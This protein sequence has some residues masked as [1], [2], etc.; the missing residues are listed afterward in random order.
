[1]AQ[2][3]KRVLVCEFHQETNTF[4]PFPM[5]LPS[6]QAGR[7]ALGQEAY[8]LCQKLPCDFHGITDAVEEAGGE[9]VSTISLLAPAGGRVD[10]RVFE[11][12]CQNVWESLEKEGPV[13]GVCAALHGATCTQS[14]DDAC[15]VFLEELR[16]RVGPDM[17]I[18]AAFDLHANVTEK[19]LRTANAVCGFQTYPHVD[20]YQTGCRAGKLC[21]RLLEKQPAFMA[22][23]AVPMI[24]PPSGYTTDDGPFRAVVELGH[25]LVRRGS[26]L[27]FTVFNV[28]P[29][30]DVTELTSRVVAVAEDPAEA[31]KAADA[32]A[33]LMFRHREEYWPELMSIDQVI[34]VAEDPTSKKPVILVDAAD[35]TNGGAVGDSVAVAMRLLERGSKLTAAMFVKDPEAAELAFR[36]GVGNTA[37]F[38]LGGKFTP[39][40]P[41]PLKA[42]G[43]VCALH[44]GWMRREGAF[45]RGTP[46]YLGKT[47]TVRIGNTDM[48]ICEK[49]AAS[50]DPQIL[51][52]FG[53]E[54]TFYDLVIVKANTSFL[55]TYGKFAGEV[56][57]ADTP[58][59]CASNLRQLVWHRIPQGLYPFDLPQNV[60]LQ[61][62]RLCT[63]GS[64]VPTEE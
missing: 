19:M 8:A 58:G 44:D 7:F 37:Q 12:F 59:A 64:A 30:L 57:Y 50:G 53:V 14:L 34:D 42:Q 16:C 1:M 47:A 52:H 4:N 31:V 56:C 20:V 5:E 2:Q 24:T 60:Q 33:Q 28:Q 32:M 43:R 48:V 13:D 38:T 10:D 40:M 22:S 51:R 29:W 55:V 49:P 36:T 6:F 62:A 9:V 11:L 18:T 39:G 17:P 41:G 25:E 3:K 26:L 46:H 27:D 35:S 45:G 61:P 23:A 63:V 21:M 54:P 15:G